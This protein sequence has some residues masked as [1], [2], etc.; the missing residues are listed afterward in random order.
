MEV[1]RL[2]ALLELAR[3]GTMAAAAEALFLTPSAVSQQIAQLEDEA[4]VELTERVG[5]GVRLTPAGHALAG[6][7]ERVM[8]VL[9][10]ARSELAELRREIAGALRVAAFPS[11]ASAV[12]PATVKALHR[13]YPRLSID[14]EELE[15][16]DAV[17]AL[18]SWRAD[19][20][21]I[22]DLS[23]ATGNHRD[24]VE[25][26]P[27]AEDV[28]YVAVAADHPLSKKSSLAIGDLRDETWAIEST[29]S[30][31]GSFVTDL[32]RRA[33]FEPRINARCR[34][35]EMVES[36]VASGCSVSVA[37][38]L[39]VLRAPAGVAWI[40]LKPEI[41]RKIYVAYRRGERSHP[42]VKVFVDEIVRTTA[43]LLG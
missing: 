30:T 25:I 15:P 42:T 27:L 43:R 8:V 3:C 6:Y 4:G 7:A 29:W 23:I 12:L 14:I 21:M 17:A 16:I 5:R 40:K 32:C 28:L 39:R 18:R 13:A 37:P 34:G 11:I 38:G 19:I 41:R 36:M 22:D 33:G 31:F 10:E 20:A 1:G 35:S 24:S 2:R 9:D 26:V